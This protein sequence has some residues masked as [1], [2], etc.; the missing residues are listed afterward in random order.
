MLEKNYD[1]QVHVEKVEGHP[2]GSIAFGLER[3]GL[4][5]VKAPILSC[6]ILLALVVGA[7]GCALFSYLLQ[8]P[9]PILTWPGAS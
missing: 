8:V 9:M 4:I 5:A 1:S 7:G 2:S 3:I 6:I